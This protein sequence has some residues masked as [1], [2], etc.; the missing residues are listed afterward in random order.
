MCGGLETCFLEAN[1]ERCFEIWS[2]K[3]FYQFY[4]RGETKPEAEQ[5][6]IALPELFHGKPSSGYFWEHLLL[7]SLFLLFASWGKKSLCHV[8]SFSS[9]I[10]LHS[11]LWSLSYCCLKVRNQVLPFLCLWK[12]SVEDNQA[13]E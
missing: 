10:I 2:Y 13:D 6:Q 8:T 7:L 11:S 5:C 3:L 9:E 4:Q 1:S 12:C